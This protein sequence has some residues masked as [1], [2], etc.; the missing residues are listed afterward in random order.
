M[1]DV[2]V[3]ITH[4]V[5]DIADRL[6]EIDGAYYPVYNLTKK[7][8]EV[9]RGEGKNSCQVVLPYDSLDARCISRVRE[10]R[11]EYVENMLRDMDRENEKIRKREEREREDRLRA[12]F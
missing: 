1:R 11:I 6:K 7:R 2:V 4:D 8:Y 9:H 12:L 3:K 10:T 5:F